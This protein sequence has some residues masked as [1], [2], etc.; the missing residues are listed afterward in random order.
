MLL[1]PAPRLDVR[2]A[3]VLHNALNVLLM[4]KLWELTLEIRVDAAK[5]RAR[6]VN[7]QIHL[8]MLIIS[9]QLAGQLALLAE[10]PLHVSHAKPL[11]AGKPF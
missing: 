11:M 9:V 10:F 4:M 7:M 1:F 3:L 2:L 8:T 6:A 5:K